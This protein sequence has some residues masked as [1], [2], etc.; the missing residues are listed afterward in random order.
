[1]KH[2]KLLTLNFLVIVF[3]TVSVQA[4]PFDF[5]DTQSPF[6][7]PLEEEKA[8]QLSEMS[9][10]FIKKIRI[11][12]NTVFLRKDLDLILKPYENRNLKSEE[13][14]E[15]KNKL[16]LFYIS[17]GYVNSG[18]VLKDQTIENETITYHIVEGILD[19]IS[20]TGNGRLRDHF[21]TSRIRLS[22]GDRETP[23][24]IN[25][26]QTRLKM[27]KQEPV[28][29]NINT[30]VKPGLKKG[31]ANLKIDVQEA[32]PYQ[33]S[34]DCNNHNSPG[35]GSYRGNLKLKHLNVLGWADSISL[36]YGGSEGLNNYKARYEIPIN[37]RDTRVHISFD[38][39]QTKVVSKSYSPLDIKGET[40]TYSLGINHYLYRTPST[41]L[42]LGLAFDKRESNTEMLGQRIPL[43]EGVEKDGVSKVSTLRCYQQWLHRSMNQVLAFYSSFNF[44][45]DVLDPTI[46][47]DESTPDG[48]FTTWLGQFQW[49]RRLQYLNSQLIASLDMRISNDPMLAIEKFSIGGAAT[50]RGYRE[51]LIVADSGVI[52]SLEWRIPLGKVAFPGLSTKSN[53]GQLYLAPFVDYG[54]GKNQNEKPEMDPENL[55]SVG[56]GFRWQIS[57]KAEAE[58]YWGAAIEDVTI[59]ADSDI[60]DDGIHF[61]ISYQL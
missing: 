15:I 56:L 31:A 53:D 47:E 45:M 24:N 21:I 10:V 39:S 52:S 40:T 27:L 23:F 51:N 9:E 17:K 19:E 54:K 16:T 2:I 61:F 33:L 36:Q 25:R 8:S 55:F 26:L 41:E 28:I 38:H 50:V 34:M 57:S 22:T 49:I 48:E 11:T 42:T 59:E 35:I 30:Y 43:S 5:M 58:F 7:P 14:H 6:L 13:L 32:R 44:G 4:D 18:C 60:Q 46:H 37:R 3:W 1:M 20:V 12:G 29:E